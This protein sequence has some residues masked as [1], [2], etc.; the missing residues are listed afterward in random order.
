MGNYYIDIFYLLGTN[1]SLDDHQLLQ[2]NIKMVERLTIVDE[3]P[4]FSLDGTDRK[5]LHFDD[6]NF[7]DDEEEEED[8]MSTTGGHVK[9]IFLVRL[10]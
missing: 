1:S 4:D 6:L 8:G 7:E 3:N 9:G 10:G 2:D 5:N